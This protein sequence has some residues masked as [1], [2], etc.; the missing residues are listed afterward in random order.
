LMR[1]QIKEYQGFIQTFVGT[2]NV[3]A[4]TFYA[5]V[6][7]TPPIVAQKGFIGRIA[8]ALGGAAHMSQKQQSESFVQQYT[9]LLQRVD[10][11]SAGLR[12]LGLRTV[13]LET[14]E[15]IELFYGLFNPSEFQQAVAEIQEE[16]DSGVL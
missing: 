7:F 10:A 1:I 16:K 14:A 8:G 5:A 13:L 15:L 3:I 6:P 2:T 9:Q 12:R 4:K 11:V